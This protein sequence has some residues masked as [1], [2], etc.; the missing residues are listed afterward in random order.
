V[1]NRRPD[2]GSGKT[3]SATCRVNTADLLAHRAYQRRL[4]YAFSLQRNGRYSRSIH[5]PNKAKAMVYNTEAK[6]SAYLAKLTRARRRR[7]RALPPKAPA[8]PLYRH[9]A[10]GMRATAT[11]GSGLML[12]KLGNVQVQASSRSQH[13]RQIQKVE[14]GHVCNS[15]WST[16]CHYSTSADHVLLW[17]HDTIYHDKCVVPGH[18]IPSSGEVHGRID[19]G[20][21]G[22]RALVIT[23]RAFLRLAPFK[24]STWPCVCIASVA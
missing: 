10:E 21:N 3:A 19:F 23:A 1:S 5:D 17:P 16:K 8:R 9:A 15:P 7:V 22:A 11:L 18:C 24:S 12:K 6:A 13:G 2:A 14:R 4:W 20:L